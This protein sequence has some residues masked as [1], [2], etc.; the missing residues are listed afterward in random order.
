MA[1]PGIYKLK[2]HCVAY[3]SFNSALVDKKTKKKTLLQIML[4]VHECHKNTKFGFCALQM[5][6]QKRI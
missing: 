4:Y 6:G 1:S 2:Y 5:Q 3:K